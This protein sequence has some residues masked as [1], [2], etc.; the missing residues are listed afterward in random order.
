MAA[1]P[2]T[3]ECDI[4]IPV[5][6]S[7]SR[8]DTQPNQP[9]RPAREV[10]VVPTYHPR[11]GYL[12]LLAYAACNLVSPI[13]TERPAVSGSEAYPVETPSPPSSRPPFLPITNHQEKTTSTHTRKS[14]LDEVPAPVSTSTPPPLKEPRR[15]PLVIRLR[16]RHQHPYKDSSYGKSCHH[17]IIGLFN[18]NYGSCSPALLKEDESQNRGISN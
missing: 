10:E 16:V 14:K 15:G 13:P 4:N 17:N 11:T 18:L 9:P 2:N 1:R 7:I 6:P 12:N 5:A 8:D 3:H